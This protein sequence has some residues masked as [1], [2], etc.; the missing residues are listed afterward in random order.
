[1]KDEF[2]CSSNERSRIK[3]EASKV[4]EHIQGSHFFFTKKN[5]KGKIIWL[6]WD[7]NPR[8]N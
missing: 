7:S 5:E 1:M 2:L 4:T 6:G 8:H 3:E